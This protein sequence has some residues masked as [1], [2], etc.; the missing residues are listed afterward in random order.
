MTLTKLEGKEGK[1]Q[2]EA[3]LEPADLK[4]GWRDPWEGSEARDAEERSASQGQEARE[5][6]SSGHALSCTTGGALRRPVEQASSLQHPSAPASL[7]SS[8]RLFALLVRREAMPAWPLGGTC[9]LWT[10]SHCGPVQPALSGRETNRRLYSRRFLARPLGV[11]GFSCFSTYR[12]GDAE[13]NRQ[14]RDEQLRPRARWYSTGWV[15]MYLG[16]LRLD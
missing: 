13:G 7:L 16:A 6:N 10:S 8:E 14:A 11:L 4:A 5:S 9:I 2:F 1:S 15:L 3:H 12:H